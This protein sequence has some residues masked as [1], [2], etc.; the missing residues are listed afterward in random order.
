MPFTDRR[1]QHL[2]TVAPLSLAML[3]MQS[4]SHGRVF[5]VP[6]A[7]FKHFQSNKTN[8]PHCVNFDIIQKSLFETNFI[9]Y[10]EKEDA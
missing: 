4:F 3:S 7:V 5:D 9:R 10:A 2:H 1:L 8:K 6:L